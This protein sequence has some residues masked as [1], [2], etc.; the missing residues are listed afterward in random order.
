MA[1]KY[2]AN[3]PS[4]R[5][6]N[7]RGFS[8][9]ISCNQ[10]GKINWQAIRRRLWATASCTSSWLQLWLRTHKHVHISFTTT[11]NQKSLMKY[12]SVFP[13]APSTVLSFTHSCSNLIPVCFL[14]QGA[15]IQALYIMSDK[16]MFFFFFSGKKLKTIKDWHT[17]KKKSFWCF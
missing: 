4:L 3:L 14:W 11:S 10:W 2:L 6:L 1:V 17:F 8:F 12:C 9:P 13:V 16:R 5:W 15:L 7:H